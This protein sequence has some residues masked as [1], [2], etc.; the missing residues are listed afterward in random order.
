MDNQ[1]SILSD[2][3]KPEVESSYV[4]RLFTN[5]IDWIIEVALFV[6]IYFMIPMESIASVLDDKPYMIYIVL[7][8][9]IFTYRFTCLLLFGK[10]VGMMI[11][12]IKYL[13]ASQQPLSS[14]QKIIAAIAIRTSTIRL[15]KN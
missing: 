4:Q 12:G 15:Y 14:K 5:I 13:D 9:L 6:G 8:I 10:T 2:I 11:C 3:E 1:D 7:F